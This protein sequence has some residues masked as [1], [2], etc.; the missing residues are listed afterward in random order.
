[1]RFWPWLR[2]EAGGQC[3]CVHA[4]RGGDQCEV[5]LAA[6]S[7]LGGGLRLLRATRPGRPGPRGSGGRELLAHAGERGCGK[8]GGGPGCARLRFLGLGVG[9]ERVE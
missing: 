8:A 5:Q 6:G 1:M 7:W 9:F 2:P 4:A 3:A